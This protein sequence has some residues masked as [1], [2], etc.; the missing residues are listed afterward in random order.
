MSTTA[1]LISRVMREMGRDDDAMAFSR[2]AEDA[3]AVDDVESQALWRSIR[4]PI[5]ARAGQTVEAESLARS[6]VALA[7]TT[8]ALTMQ[9]DTARELATVLWLA[10]Q[11]EESRR[12]ID[13]AIG[14]YEAKGDIVSAARARAWRDQLGG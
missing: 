9:G 2:V 5:L 4:A 6:A 1:A 8:D 11:P 3:A 10:G 7:Q 14:I 13:A 12:S